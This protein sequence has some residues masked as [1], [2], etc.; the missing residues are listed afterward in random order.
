MGYSRIKLSVR[1]KLFLGTFRR[2]FLSV[3]RPGYVRASLAKRQGECR[4]CGVCCRL[5]WRCR[6]CLDDDGIPHCRIYTIYRFPNCTQF[7]IDQSDLADR[8]LISPDTICGYSW[9]LPEKKR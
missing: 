3:C 5:A 1:L 6:Y 4:R 2:F 8:E 9:A 7:P